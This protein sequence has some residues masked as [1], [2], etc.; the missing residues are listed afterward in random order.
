MEYVEKNFVPP[1]RPSSSIRKWTALL[2]CFSL[3]WVFIFVVAPMFRKIPMV[4]TL[5]S[6]IEETGINASALYYTEVEEAAVAELG[7]R[8][9]IKFPPVGPSK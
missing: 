1:V 2:C 8:G 7:A 4:N 9:T 3:I 5:T 6:Y